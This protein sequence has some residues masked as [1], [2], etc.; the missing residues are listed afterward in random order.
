MKLTRAIRAGNYLESQN[1]PKRKTTFDVEALKL[2]FWQV[3]RSSVKDNGL[4]SIPFEKAKTESGSSRRAERGRSSLS[5]DTV[6]SDG[7]I[8]FWMLEGQELGKHR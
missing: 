6:A 1:A 4:R 7:E 2:M 3:T 8:K 5:E